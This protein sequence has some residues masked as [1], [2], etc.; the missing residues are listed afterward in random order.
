MDT[1][2]INCTCPGCKKPFSTYL[3]QPLSPASSQPSYWICSCLTPGCIY[4]GVTL[5]D[6]Q[7]TKLISDP[8]MQAQ[9]K[10]QVIVRRM[11]PAELRV[12]YAAKIGA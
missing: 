5:D 10:E 1:N 4:E 11:S 3:Q 9:Y 2:I 12:Y 6:S 8:A 7:W